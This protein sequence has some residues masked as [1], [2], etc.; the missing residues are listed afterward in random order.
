MGIIPKDY[1]TKDGD[2]FILDLESYD[3]NIPSLK[4]QDYEH[5]DSIRFIHENFLYFGVL[6]GQI[7]PTLF[8]II[9]VEKLKEI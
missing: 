2:K 8:D 9:K 6:V 4:K 1:I 3:I 5:G 7:D